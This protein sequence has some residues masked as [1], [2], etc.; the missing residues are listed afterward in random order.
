[1]RGGHLGAIWTF[2]IR[3]F[4]MWRSYRSNQLMWVLAILMNS[5]LFFLIGRMVG[6][7][8]ADLLGAYGTNYMTFVLI[9]IAVNYLVATNLS[10]PYAR[11][12][13]VYWDGTMDLYLLSP[14]SIFTPLIG[15]MARSVIDDYP[16]VLFVIVFGVTLFGARFSGANIPAALLFSEMVWT[17]KY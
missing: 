10:D 14:M 1:M 7:N 17:W 13:R 16:R 2:G 6:E 15:L 5:F 4:R 9:G 12:A 11:V 8:S 3:E